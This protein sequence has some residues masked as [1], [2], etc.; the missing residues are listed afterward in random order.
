MEKD[1]EQFSPYPR[2]ILRRKI[3]GA[4]GRFLLKVFARPRIEGLENIPE[5]GPVILAG[6]HVSSLEPAFMFLFTD[7][8]VEPIGAGDMPFDGALDL[9]VNFYG[10][11]PI[12][13]GQLDRKAMN[14][15]LSVL[16]Q[17]GFLGIY[18]EGGTWN[19]GNM[20]AHIGVSWLSHKGQAKVVPIGFS[21]FR[22]SFGKVFK[23]KRP[24]FIMK[25]GEAIPALSTENDGRPIKEIY[26]EYADHVMERVRELI[27]PA[28]FLEIPSETEFALDILKENDKVSTLPGHDT[29]AQFFHNQ[30]MLESLLN[31][32]KKPIKLLFPEEQ[33]R[34][35]PGF[36]QA[37]RASL[38]ILQENAG[39][40]T[41]RFG[42]ER[43][44]ELE[45]AI[46][47][48]IEF[49][50]NESGD[51]EIRLLA[52]ARYRYPDGRVEEL[53]HTYELSAA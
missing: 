7:R 49:L 2:L 5:E 30:V 20:H 33:E 26:Q 15:A 1:N 52:K 25:V 39:F 40:F 35:I 28:E 37:L 13:R 36:V 34:T 48:L 42:M 31:N 46:R 47:R 14:K 21:G 53:S 19:P 11:I 27:D 41:Y 9:I 12:N 51:H 8:Q 45:A 23:F 43:G 38:E 18:P 24:V 3:L 4:L 29:I 22:D 16:E 10:Y 17:D 50:E 32:L 6:N 44:R